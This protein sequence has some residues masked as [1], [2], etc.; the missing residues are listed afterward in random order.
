MA[1][2]K[3]EKKSRKVEPAVYPAVPEKPLAINLEYI[4]A[5]AKADTKVKDWY[6][7]YYKEHKEIK[8]PEVRKDYIANFWKDAFKKVPVKKVNQM[9]ALFE[10]LTK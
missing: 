5:H 1:D 6:I 3:K 7:K 2:E 8:F 4:A 10:E 9:Q